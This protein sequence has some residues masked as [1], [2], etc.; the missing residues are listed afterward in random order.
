MG[1]P[2]HVAYT[3]PDRHEEPT[4]ERQAHYSRRRRA[5]GWLVGWSVGRSVG[6]SFTRSQKARNRRGGGEGGWEHDGDAR[7]AAAGK[8]GRE[9]RETILSHG[10]DPQ[11]L[12]GGEADG[13]KGEREEEEGG[14][15]RAKTAVADGAPERRKRERRSEAFC[16]RVA[17]CRIVVTPSRATPSRA[18]PRLD[19]PRRLGRDAPRRNC[20]GRVSRRVRVACA[21]SC[22]ARRHAPGRVVDGGGARPAR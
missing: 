2:P 22:A 18:T 14:T 21:C 10:E 17:S 16:V 1:T 5:V 19:R 13:E 4:H 8:S 3:Y 7:V 6:R 12:L 9:R 15:R 20:Q 11:E